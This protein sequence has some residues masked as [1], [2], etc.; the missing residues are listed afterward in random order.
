[1][2]NA[3]ALHTLQLMQL[4]YN[5][6]PMISAQQLYQLLCTSWKAGGPSTAEDLLP[7]IQAD[8]Q[9]AKIFVPSPLHESQI[10]L[11]MAD[12][13]FTEFLKS[14]SSQFLVIHDA[15][16][17][18]GDASLST[19]SY[20]CALV[21]EILSVPGL[22]TLNFFCGLH[23][24]HGSLLEG[25]SG[26]MRSLTLQLLQPFENTSFPTQNDPSQV[27]QGL[28]VNDLET[29]CAVFTMLLQ[30]IPAGVVY[31]MVDGAFWYGT[32]MRRD[33]MSAVMLFLNRLVGEVQAAS[34][35]LVLK[36]LVTNPTARQRSSWGV[37]QAVDIYL[38][39]DFV[40]GGNGGDVARLLT[41]L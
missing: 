15:K 14:L 35:G 31:V 8:L 13:S 1:M 39:R 34:R 17:L 28:M 25:G 16:A 26:L 20:L 9:T 21:S 29:I 2:R 40:A 6:Q 18:E 11:L 24:A 41:A 23:S 33:D 38:E 12:D 37:G 10:G 7:T 32:E 19:S 27:I 22:F 5:A 30:S 36:V 4:S 3:N